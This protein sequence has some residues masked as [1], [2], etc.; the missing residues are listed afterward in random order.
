MGFGIP[1]PSIL[2]SL[3]KGTQYNTLGGIQNLGETEPA[4][5]QSEGISGTDLNIPNYKAVYIWE[6]T[7]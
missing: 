2:P 5:V 6:R 1:V 4:S 7:V 3:S